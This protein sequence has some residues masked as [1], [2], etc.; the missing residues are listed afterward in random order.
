VFVG[1]VTVMISHIRSTE[2]VTLCTG[3]AEPLGAYEYIETV[4]ERQCHLSYNFSNAAECI[5]VS[6]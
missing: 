5:Q 2:L 1:Y 4:R 3:L 6:F